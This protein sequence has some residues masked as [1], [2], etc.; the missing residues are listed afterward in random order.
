MNNH[1][2]FFL[3]IIPIPNTMA[4]ASSMFTKSVARS[5]GSSFPLRPKIRTAA[6]ADPQRTDRV[7]MI[8]LLLSVM[9]FG[10]RY[11][12]FGIRYSVFG[13]R[14]SV[15]SIR[16]SVFGLRSS[17]FSLRSSVISK[18]SGKH[19]SSNQPSGCSL[20]FR[21]RRIFQVPQKYRFY[22]FFQDPG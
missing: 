20:A 15:I 21:F 18:Q 8:V 5:V 6:M 1:F 4:A 12:V 11:S 10:I 7:M 3:K 2:F 22:S 13:V 17:V 9:V 16:P 19:S 14:L